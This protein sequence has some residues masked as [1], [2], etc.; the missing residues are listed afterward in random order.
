MKNKFLLFTFFLLSFRA[1]S[2]EKISLEGEWTGIDKEDKIGYIH[3]SPNGIVYIMVEG[4]KLGGENVQMGEHKVSLVYRTNENVIPH[5]IDL[6]M[7]LP[8][9]ENKEFEKL[10]GIYEFTA[11]KKLRLC[12]NF[13]SQE[14][15]VNFNN[16]ADVILLE[17][18]K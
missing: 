6:I 12:L 16:K 9:Y 8:D 11:D 13:D 1:L 18:V 3:F 17:K 10:P 4:E 5:T 15:P 2:Q 7:V 14:R